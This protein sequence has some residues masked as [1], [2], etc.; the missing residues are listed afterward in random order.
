MACPRNEVRSDSP[1]KALPVQTSSPI[2]LPSLSN[3]IC[4]LELGTGLTLVY[5]RSVWLLGK[6]MLACCLCLCGRLGS[7]VAQSIQGRKGEDGKTKV[8]Q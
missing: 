7:P 6:Q 3:I 1:H 5:T 2:I 8:A 4:A